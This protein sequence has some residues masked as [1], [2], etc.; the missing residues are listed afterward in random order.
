ML[1]NCAALENTNENAP[2]RGQ[3]TQISAGAN[4]AVYSESLSYAADGD[5]ASVNGAWTY[6]YDPLNRLAQA[7]CGSAEALAQPVEKSA[8]PPR[9]SKISSAR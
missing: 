1:I 8:E 9:S 7:N 6:Q 3:L 4:G 5:V 2:G